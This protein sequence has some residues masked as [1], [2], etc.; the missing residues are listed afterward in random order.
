MNEKLFTDF[1]FTATDDGKIVKIRTK[2]GTYYT[3]KELQIA[4]YSKDI[5]V[6]KDKLNNLISI[7]Y[8]EIEAVMSAEVEK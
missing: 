4:P 1:F 2:T 7:A 6:F 8:A 5:L 3:I